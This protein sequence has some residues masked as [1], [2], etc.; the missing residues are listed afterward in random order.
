[1]KILVGVKRVVDHN[2]HVTV[3]S[4]GSG[5]AIEG[6]KMSVN[7]FDEIA[8][9]EA[10]RIKEAGNADEV[11]VVSIGPKQSQEQ[12]RTTLAMGADRAVQV[13]T[14]DELQPLTI[15]RILAAVAKK[16][17]AGL[18]IVG[19]QAIDG[20]NGQTGPM[21]ATVL[22]WAHATQVSEIKIDGGKATITRETD[23]GMMTIDVDLPAVIAA[24]LR[25]N[26]PRYIKLPAIMK[27]KKKP[28]ES[29][30]LA[31]LGIEIAPGLTT[32]KIAPPA[33][34]AG[35]VKVESVEAL[36]AIL[37]DKGLV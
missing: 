37:K 17:D 33:K 16:E 19:K 36:V 35:G 28:M 29:I 6:A 9:E 24:D 11:I 3:K 10:L 2:V 12:L 8:V 13:E 4:D 21:T 31:D 30:P 5:V 20:D 23:S 27:A 34:R 18:V 7:P 22:D 32:T 1:M 15:A 14:D 25:L 26:E